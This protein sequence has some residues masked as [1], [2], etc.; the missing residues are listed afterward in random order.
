MR[1]DL[2]VR[3]GRALLHV[4]HDDDALAADLLAIAEIS[5][6]FS[7]AA[8]LIAT[9]STPRPMIVLACSTVLMPPP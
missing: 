9:F 8:E 6:G 7:I 4:E 3:A 1:P 5:V 2:V